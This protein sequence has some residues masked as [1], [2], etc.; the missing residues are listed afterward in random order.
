MREKLKEQGFKATPDNIRKAKAQFE[1]A[2]PEGTVR[3][4]RDGK[5]KEWIGN[6][7]LLAGAK[8]YIPQFTDMS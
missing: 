7:Y 5:R 2:N 1:S 8:V 3:T 4:Y 6:Q